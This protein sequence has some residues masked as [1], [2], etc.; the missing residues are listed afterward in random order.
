MGVRIENLDVG[1]LVTDGKARYGRVAKC[2]HGYRYYTYL[3]ERGK[4]CATQ[5]GE[6]AVTVSDYD[7]VYAECCV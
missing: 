1:T 4:A 5:E 3:A 6:D 2:V 7:T